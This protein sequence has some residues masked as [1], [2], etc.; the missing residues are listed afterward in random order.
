MSLLWEPEIITPGR[1]LSC[2][3]LQCCLTAFQTGTT[4]KMWSTPM[5]LNHHSGQGDL[6]LLECFTFLWAI[7]CKQQRSQATALQ[8]NSYIS[9]VWKC[10]N[11]NLEIAGIWRYKSTINKIRGCTLI[12]I[13]PR[14]KSNCTDT[15]LHFKTIHA[16]ERLHLNHDFSN[17]LVRPCITT[18]TTT[19]GG[20]WLCVYMEQQ[21]GKEMTT[22]ATEGTTTFRDH[23]PLRRT[24]F[25]A[26]TSAGHLH[27]FL[28]PFHA[29]V[30]LLTVGQQR[31][32]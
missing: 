19:S 31:R 20:V 4:K 13:R 3:I 32:N 29:A 22:P 2:I 28:L 5:I 12:V 7:S 15:T 23:P 9:S 21:H 30:Q 18:F 6:K 8:K 11:L 26:A 16:E 27:S 14:L 24:S 1:L 17:S 25:W 10:L